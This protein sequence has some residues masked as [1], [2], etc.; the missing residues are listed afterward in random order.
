MQNTV[1]VIEALALEHNIGSLLV[2][3]VV[4]LFF[5]IATHLNDAQLWESNLCP[6][7]YRDGSSLGVMYKGS[8]DHESWLDPCVA[9][10][11]HTTLT[12]SKVF[13]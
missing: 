8:V 5:S 2:T 3:I 7:A 4:R 11:R 9:R 6:K 13:V 12:K 10:L 1:G